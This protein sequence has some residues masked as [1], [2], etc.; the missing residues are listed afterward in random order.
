M[1][2]G[3]F[4]QVPGKEKAALHRVPGRFPERRL[5]GA[6]LLALFE[7]REA[8]ALVLGDFVAGRKRVDRAFAGLSR[9]VVEGH[10]LTA[11]QLLETRV[12]EIG[13]TAFFADCAECHGGLF[14]FLGGLGGNQEVR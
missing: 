5:T 3:F 1:I 8:G 7:K 6:L 4:M 13:F 9:E 12:E 2:R 14:P 10:F 11:A